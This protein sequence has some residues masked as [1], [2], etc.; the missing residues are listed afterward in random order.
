MIQ[1]FGKKLNVT[2][3]RKGIAVLLT[4]WLNLALLPCAMA[5][6]VPDEAHDCCPPTI[7]LQPSDC[8]DLGDI[9]LDSRDDGVESPD[10]PGFVTIDKSWLSLNTITAIQWSEKPPDPVYH[11]PPR[12]KIFC[13]YLD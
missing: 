13:V 8:C 12:H 7:E 11:S 2:T 1:L 5:M 3:S 9:A 4:F 10:E 6:E